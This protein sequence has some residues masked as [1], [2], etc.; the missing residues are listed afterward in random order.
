M[1]GAHGTEL[2]PD[3]YHLVTRKTYIQRVKDLVET[4]GIV[5]YLIYYLV[6]MIYYLF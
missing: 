1:G 4:L 2:V 3:F 6:Y 5:Y